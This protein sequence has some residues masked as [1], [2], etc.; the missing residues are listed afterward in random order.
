MRFSGLLV[1]S[2]S[3]IAHICTVS[4]AHVSAVKDELTKRDTRSAPLLASFP[5]QGLLPTLEQILTFNATNGTFLPIQNI[6][7]DILVGMKK[8]KE[9]FVFFHINDP[10]RFK[11]VL[12]T[13]ASANITSVAT[14]VSPPSSQPL[15]FVNVAFSQTGLTTLGVSDNL[16]DTQFA[17]GQFADASGLGDDI[18]K[19]ETA[20][21]G[22]NI[23]GVFLIGSDQDSYLTAYNNDLNKLFGSSLSVIY[24]LNSAARPGAQ[25]GHEHFGFLDGISNPAVIGFNDPL[26]GQTL[27]LPGIILTGR[28]GDGTFTRPSWTKDGSFL[29][30]RKLKQLVPEFNK[31][32]LDN[33][34]QNKAGT[35]TVQE[36]AEFIGA[37][38]IG[39]WKSGA[40]LDIVPE[41]D[42]PTLGADPQ[43][44]NKFD[45]AHLTSNLISDQTYCPFSA[46]IRKT[47]PRADLADANTI[48]HAIRAGTPYGPEASAA[49]AH[50]NTT[51]TDRGLAFVEYQS[52]I[53]N[54]FRFQQV[55]WANTANFPPLKSVNAGFDPVIG[56]GTPR[57]AVGLDPN[58]QTKSYTLPDFVVSNGGEYFFSPS[59]SAITGTIAA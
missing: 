50:A 21:K 24:T 33:A 11:G 20:F 32:T 6:Q 53:A 51:Q 31:W 13:Y 29:V 58:D 46:H 3:F 36:G 23:H 34:V 25:A 49:E 22:T 57:T 55:N 1:A 48:N 45:F 17:S 39:R 41:T 44:N 9:R 15:A 16:G 7:G 54:G 47:N 26:P 42:D 18:N 14:L 27:V 35:L 52:S 43:R 37:R 59:I 30:F 5:G 4:G 12:K 40:P 56:R 2:L 19:W 28:L 10:T 8:Q 38:M